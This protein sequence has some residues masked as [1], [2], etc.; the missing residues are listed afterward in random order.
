[1]SLAIGEAL[2][3]CW[4]IVLNKLNCRHWGLKFVFKGPFGLVEL[5]LYYRAIK[6]SPS[7]LVLKDKLV[8]FK[9][10][11]DFFLLVSFALL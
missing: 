7:G 1:M 3:K 11:F 6:I 2:I 9:V 10:A 8:K 4:L 5:G